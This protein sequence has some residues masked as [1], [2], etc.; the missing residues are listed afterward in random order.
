MLRA[1]NYPVLNDL[2]LKSPQEIAK[3]GEVLVLK[4]DFC[5]TSFVN[6]Q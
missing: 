5:P 4:G 2:A 3:E 1:F 6:N